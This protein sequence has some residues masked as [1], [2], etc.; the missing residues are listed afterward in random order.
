MT[1]RLKRRHWQAARWRRVDGELAGSRRRSSNC[2]AEQQQMMSYMSYWRLALTQALDV[3]AAAARTM[4]ASRIIARGAGRTARTR[5][6]RALVLGAA[7]HVVT[8]AHARSRIHVVQRN[9]TRKVT[10]RPRYTR[11]MHHTTIR[12]NAPSWTDVHKAKPAPR[13][14]HVMQPS[15]GRTR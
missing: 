15:V 14:N 6:S 11:G 8:Q 7:H 10:T 5:Q 3:A 2:P 1:L 13:I 9:Q 4:R 12:N